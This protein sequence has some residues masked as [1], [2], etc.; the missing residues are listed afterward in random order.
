MASHFET[1]QYNSLGMVSGCPDEFLRSTFVFFDDLFFGNTSGTDSHFLWHIIHRLLAWLHHLIRHKVPW[2]WYF[3]QVHHSQKE[4]NLFTDFRVHFV[5]HLIANTVI[6]FPLSVFA[7]DAP[8]IL[9][10]LFFSMFYTRF[11]HGNVRTN[12]GPLRYIL[13]TPQLH[14][15][16]HS[17]RREHQDK[18]FGVLFCIW[19]R[20]F[21]TFLEDG[22]YP[23][24]GISDEAFPCLEQSGAWGILQNAAAQ[25]AYPFQKIYAST[26]DAARSLPT[27]R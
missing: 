15:I 4:L 20:L 10:F 8:E 24:T 21:G 16:H 17:S 23:E 3:H 25:I 26:V 1:V 11:Y 6:I 12:M 13:I 9:L 7:Y 22:T 14:R 27:I 19:D 18:N 2:F 5:D